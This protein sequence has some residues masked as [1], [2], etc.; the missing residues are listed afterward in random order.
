MVP[1]LGAGQPA[2][3]PQVVIENNTIRA[4]GVPADPGNSDQYEITAGI[5]LINAVATSVAGNVIENAEIG[6][7][8]VEA[9]DLQGGTDNT[10]TSVF[11]G[12]FLGGE[13]EW[14]PGTAVLNFNDITSQSA[15]SGPGSTPSNFRCN[16]WG[17]GNPL[18]LHEIGA[19]F[20][21]SLYTPLAI[22]PIANTPEPRGCTP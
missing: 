15:I 19:P 22:T 11:T 3:A 7:G 21:A 17:G 10:L 20:P 16:Y 8:S 4:L 6:I 14:D 1:L 5:A 13:G 2:D 9:S 12:I 18:N